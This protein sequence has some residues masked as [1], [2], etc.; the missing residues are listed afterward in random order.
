[1]NAL[2]KIMFVIDTLEVG[3]AERSLLEIASRFDPN[4]F[5]PVV[6]S[7]YRGSTLKNEFEAAGIRVTEL[8]LAG[9][10]QFPTAWLRLKRLAKDERPSLI[11][12]ML[13]RADQIGRTV[14]RW[15]GIPVISS[16]VNVPYDPVRLEANPNLSR[17]KVGT[18][19]LI[20]SISARCVTRFHAVSNAV[21]DS[22]CRRLGVATERVTVIPRGRTLPESRACFNGRLQQLRS[23]LELAGCYPV[24]LNVGR[25]I[26]QKAQTDLIRAMPRIVQEFPK[27]RLLIAGEGSLR[28]ELEQ[29]IEQQRLTGCVHLLGNRPDVGDLLQLADCFAFPSC[30]E[31]LPGAVVEAMLA[32]RPI[33]A[34][35]IPMIRDMI[36]DQ[37]SGLLVP[38][39]DPESLAAGIVRIA[40]D[41]TLANNLAQAAE[42]NA[43]ERFNMD[44]VVAQTEALYDQ[45]LSATVTETQ[46]TLAT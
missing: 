31:G 2:R 30:Y 36:E 13:F 10:Y 15:L 21:R 8:G 6:C 34:T 32:G 1:M 9:K 17:W 46:K 5:E 27:S 19:R 23:S 33:V 26:G 29:Q 42:T 44:R 14:G 37:M 25:L 28:K 3:G 39:Q 12:T 20:D 45:V 24:I 18:F 35:D 22:N 41:R 4:R 40:R 43:R 11:H 38:P 7:V 16:L